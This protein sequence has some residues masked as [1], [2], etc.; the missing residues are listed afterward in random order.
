V[1]IVRALVASLGVT[2][3]VAAASTGTIKG[4]VMINGKLPGNSVIRMSV[5]PKC[6]QINAGKRVLQEAVAATADGGLANVFVRVLGSFP[7]TPVSAEPVTID[8]H[9][10][11]YGPRVVGVRVGQTLRIRND[12]ALLHDVHSSSAVGNS[13]NV[14]QPA[15]GL[16]YEFKPKAEEVMLK[17][18][19]DIHT[20]MTAYV[21]VVTNPYFAVSGSGGMFEITNVPAGTYTIEAWHERLGKVTKTVIV[22]SGLAASADFVYSSGPP[23]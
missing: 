19:C 23:R 7:Q 16:I 3:F 6:A 14:A 18:G 21:G 15:A 1:K 20:W 13:F 17:L 5:D 22:R 8:Q 10:C 4:H 2:M 11:V 9:G 12:D